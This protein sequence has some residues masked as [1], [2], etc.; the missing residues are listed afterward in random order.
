MSAFLSRSTASTTTCHKAP[1][2][3]GWRG[4]WTTWCDLKQA[5]LPFLF[6]MPCAGL[7]GLAAGWHGV[8]WP[9]TAVTGRMGRH[10]TLRTTGDATRDG[11]RIL[12]TR[13]MAWRGV[14][15]LRWNVASIFMGGHET[16]AVGKT[17]GVV[18]KRR[19]AI[20]TW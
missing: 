5:F 4:R 2:P 15:L 11:A 1:P 10:Q 12:R 13:S 19:H 14:C 8:A 18:A 6:G 7:L 9:H 3:P 20:V 17:A 16:M